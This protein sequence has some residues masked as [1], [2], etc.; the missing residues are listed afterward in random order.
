[1]QAREIATSVTTYTSAGGA[2][3]FGFSANEIAAFTGAVVAVASFL[4]N[5]WFKSQHL[6]IVREK[7]SCAKDGGICPGI[8]G[9][10]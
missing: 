1:M 7:A 9:D 5:W 4:L 2:I 8:S 10:D 3:L 6:A